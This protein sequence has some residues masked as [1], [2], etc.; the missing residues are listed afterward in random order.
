[1]NQLQTFKNDLFEVGVTLENGEVLFEIEHVAR[2]L[3][4]TEMKNGMEYV[5]W[6][7]VNNYLPSHSPQVAKGDLIPEALVY[8][9]SFKASNY[10]AERFQDWLAIEVIPSIRKT[11]SYQVE[12]PSSTKLLL[13]AALEQVGRIEVVETDVKYLKNHMRI[14]GA[15]EYRINKNGRGK[16]VECLGG[17]DSKAYKEISKVIFSQFWNEFKKHFEIPRYGELPKVRFE[18][19]IQFIEEWSPDTSTRLEIKTLNSQ[20]HL[21][22]AE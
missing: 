21:R 9:L 1:M 8:K 14:N 4:L 6:K 15:Q 16:V 17:K 11:G 18:D 12:Q 5:R 3:G 7:R 13:Q 2:C 10:L 22:L 19:A 20:Q